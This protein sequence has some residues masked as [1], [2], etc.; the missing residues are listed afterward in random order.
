MKPVPA[1]YPVKR[2]WSGRSPALNNRGDGSQDHTLD[3]R[4]TVTVE[5]SLSV[6]GSGGRTDA[7]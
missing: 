7:R 6:N 3:D 1:K 4:D 2:F 5:A